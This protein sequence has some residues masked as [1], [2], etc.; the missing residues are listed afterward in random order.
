MDLRQGEYIQKV[1]HHHPTPFVFTL[2]KLV[3]FT[4]P[5][6]LLLFILQTAFSPKVLMILNVVI[7]VIFALIVIYNALVYW[8]DKL[9]VT[10]LRIIFID[11]RYLTI[12]KESEAMLDDIQE[13]NTKENGILSK[14][15]IFDYGTFTLQTASHK[16]TL[17]FEQAPD[18]ESMRQYIYRVRKQ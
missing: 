4:V 15:W 16:V 10:N 1:F 17:T 12:K 6:Y 11:W 14:L 5:F 13:I 18:P 9:V 3:F 2:I 8:L 7:F